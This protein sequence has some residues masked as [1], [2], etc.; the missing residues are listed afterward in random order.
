MALQDQYR[1]GLGWVWI[2]VF[3][4]GIGI[5]SLSSSMRAVCIGI[6]G[7]SEVIVVLPLSMVGIGC[8]GVASVGWGLHRG[9]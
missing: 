3:G 1:S 9:R 6:I 4:G 2:V 7:V 8:V 5:P